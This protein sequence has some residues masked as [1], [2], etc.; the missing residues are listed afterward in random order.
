[1]ATNP[2]KAQLVNE[3]NQIV[4]LTTKQNEHYVRSR[5]YLYEGFA[6]VYL[7]WLKAKAVDGFLEEQYKLH[8]IGGQAHEQEKFTRVL[9]LTWRLDWADESKAKLQ[10]WSNALRKLDEEYKRNK[11]AYRTDAHKKLVLYIE[12]MGGLRK[13]IGA[14]KYDNDTDADTE[15][16]GKGKRNPARNEADEALIAQKHLQL[17]SE[18]FDNATAISNIQ[19]TKPILVNR[20]GYAVAL[21]RQKRGG[22]YDVLATLN[23]ES[24]IQQAIIS[25]YRRTNTVAPV[26]LRVLTEVI[27]TQ[28][29]PVAMEKHRYTM[30]DSITVTDKDGKKVKLNQNKRV[31]FRK[32]QGDILLS[33]NRTGC[34]VVTLAKPKASVL[35]SSK[36]VFLNVNDRR[37]LEQAII[38]RNELSFYT[39]ND[40]DKVPVLRDTERVASHRLVVENKVLDKKR[41]IYFYTLDTVSDTSRPQAS[42]KA[43]ADMSSA[44]T[45]SVNKLWFEK[46]NTLFVSGWLREYG[47]RITWA[48]HKLMCLEFDSKRL[49]VHHYGERGNFSNKSLPLDLP[50]AGVGKAI[51]VN[52]LSKDILPVLSGLADTEIKGNVSLTVVQGAVA[53]GYATELASYKVYVP[54]CGVN[55]KRNQAMFEAYGG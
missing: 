26:V 50:K 21:I 33:E 49:V 11:D 45:A 29:L 15:K 43:D 44:F 6:N 16:K 46:I 51:K 12:T 22:K 36:D 25:S 28:S 30:P 48:K 13:L 23:N 40:K 18:Y 14:D 19:S 1:M 2:T 38:Q 34:S 35:T 3:L 24:Q 20:L 10:Q 32:R 7:W 42:I 47:E 55:G 52:V 41:G 4:E 9:R 17:G 31:L 27:Q 8:N 53:I 37:Y 39:A 5:Q 54:T